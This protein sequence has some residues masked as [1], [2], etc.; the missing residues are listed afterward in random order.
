MDLS[1]LQIFVEVVRQGRFAAVARD[2]NVDP[3]SI[4]RAIASLEKELGVRLFQRTTR[5]LTPTEAGSLYYEKV[6]PLMAQLAQAGTAITEVTG[7]PQGTLR[8]TASVSFGLTC[9]VPHLADF[10]ATYSDMHVDLVLSDAVLDL[11]NERIDLAIRLG[12]MADASL[13]AKR[14]M[15]TKYVVCASPTYIKHHG[16]PDTPTALAR[17]KC[18]RFPFAGF[19]TRWLFKDG[20]GQVEEVAIQGKTVISNAIALRECAIAHM[21]ASLLPNWLVQPDL[22]TGHLINLFPHHTV[23]ATTFDTA[24]WF[25]YPSKRYKPLKID[26]FMAFLKE[27]LNN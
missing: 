16:R 27:R 17:H 5:Q 4:S 1:K 24:A 3:S 20:Q 14:L 25:V 22:T 11:V 19:R 13:I 8:V 7:Q 18:L 9:I 21:G 26:I 15:P 12:M 2:R 6:A 23:T 10:Q